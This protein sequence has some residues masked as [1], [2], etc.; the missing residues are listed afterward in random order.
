VDL[1][2]NTVEACAYTDIGAAAVTVLESNPRF[3]VG[4]ADR[5]RSQATQREREP[6]ALIIDKQ[7]SS[8]A[9]AGFGFVIPHVVRRQIRRR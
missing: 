9:F 5:V 4:Q 1:G 2:N 3:V 6:L 7:Q 8:A